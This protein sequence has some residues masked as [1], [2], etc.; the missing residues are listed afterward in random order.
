MPPGAP[1]EPSR[2]MRPRAGLVLAAAEAGDD[3]RQGDRPEHEQH[4][5]RDEHRQALCEPQLPVEEDGNVGS[6]PTRKIASAISSKL[7]MKQVSHA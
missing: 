6:P 3:H 2:A 4:R 1:G 7:T 5:P